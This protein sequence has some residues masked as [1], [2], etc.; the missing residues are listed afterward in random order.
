MTCKD[1]WRDTALSAAA[2]TGLVNAVNFLLKESSIDPNSQNR[3]GDSALH[4]TAWNGD[5]AVTEILVN[6]PGVNV[7]LRAK[8]LSEMSPCLAAASRGREEVFMYLAAQSGVDVNSVGGAPTTALHIAADG[9]N[10]P[11]VKYLVTSDPTK[12][13]ARDYLRRT[14]FLIAMDRGHEETAIYLAKQPGV[15]L[16]AHSEYC[17]VGETPIL[18]AVRHNWSWKKMDPLLRFLVQQDSIDLIFKDR[19]GFT[20]LDQAKQVGNEEAVSILEAALAKRGIERTS[21]A[22]ESDQNMEDENG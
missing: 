10:L 3:R 9:G 11:I 21:E 15:D 7:D 14:P 6:T 5:L 17:G 1:T 18:L 13:D 16:N 8:G 4:H 12:V 2:A 22:V 19:D 20:A